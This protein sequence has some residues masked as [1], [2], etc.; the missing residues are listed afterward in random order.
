MSSFSQPVSR[1]P[2]PSLQDLQSLQPS[3]HEGRRYSPDAQM[4]GALD[5]MDEIFQDSQQSV[6]WHMDQIARLDALAGN[7]DSATRPH[8]G[9]A[10][11]MHTLPAPQRTQPQ[12]APAMRV[13]EPAYISR[14][15]DTYVYN[16]NQNYLVD[17]TRVNIRHNQR[18]LAEY[19]AAM[20]IAEAQQPSTA[21]RRT[22]RIAEWGF[23]GSI[24]YTAEIRDTGLSRDRFEQIMNEIRELRAYGLATSFDWMSYLCIAVGTC[25]IGA[26]CTCCYQTPNQNYDQ[27]GA[28]LSKHLRNVNAQLVS[29]GVPVVFQVSVLPDT[30]IRLSMHHGA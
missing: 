6:A 10:Y 27:L 8:S 14:T 4:S 16:G 17:N 15:P 30:D 9:D 5:R 25:G 13:P 24:E 28:S 18:A 23:C 3:A 2:V 19:E 22:G 29:E 7:S 20:L 11:E 21:P 12:A 1:R 26:C